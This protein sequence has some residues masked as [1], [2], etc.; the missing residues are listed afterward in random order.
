MTTDASKKAWG[1]S[2]FGECTGGWFTLKELPFSIN[3]KE[4]LAPLGSIHSE[5]SVKRQRKCLQFRLVWLHML[6]TGIFTVGVNASVSISV[7][8]DAPY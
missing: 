3:T 8:A 5:R 7:N 1:A 4:T 2:L 6:L